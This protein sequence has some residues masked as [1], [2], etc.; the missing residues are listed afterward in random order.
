MVDFHCYHQIQVPAAQ[1]LRSL[2]VSSNQLTSLEG[3]DAGQPGWILR[4]AG[5]VDKESLN[6]KGMQQWLIERIWAN[7]WTKW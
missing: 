4:G 6:K 3:L 1:G 5:H 7:S 2:V